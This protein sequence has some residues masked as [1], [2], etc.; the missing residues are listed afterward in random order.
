[1][2]SV[3]IWTFSLKCFVQFYLNF[4]KHEHFFDQI[5]YTMNYK[6]TVFYF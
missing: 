2:K 3:G 4:E 5:E 6:F 1:M